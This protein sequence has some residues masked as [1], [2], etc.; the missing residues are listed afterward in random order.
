MRIV[1]TL[2]LFV[3]V[4]WAS[5][6]GGTYKKIEVEHPTSSFKMVSLKMIY[7][8]EVNKEEMGDFKKTLLVALEKRGIVVAEQSGDYPEL[9]VEIV[10]FHKENLAEKSF[11]YLN[12]L[13][14]INYSNHA[15]EIKVLIKDKNRV[16]ELREFE[17]F[18]EN[19]R[20]W[21][22]LKRTVADRIS[23][24]VYFALLAM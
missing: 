17:N 15:I 11:R 24:A 10:K 22:D 1:T 5:G 3:M 2:F 14:I 6:C 12:P 9:N 8:K 23:E 13:S 18:K 19:I 21:E 4:L 7:L 16:I 20:N